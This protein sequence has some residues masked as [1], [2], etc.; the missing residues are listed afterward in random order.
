[1]NAIPDHLPSITPP[2]APGASVDVKAVI[3]LAA[4]NA[5]S[6]SE[7]AELRAAS[8]RFSALIDAGKFLAGN[9][10]G[11]ITPG[12]LARWNAALAGVGGA[13]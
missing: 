8:E 1:M 4:C 13:E 7:A 3:E 12:A 5:E 11:M 10:L 6:H 2:V 9:P